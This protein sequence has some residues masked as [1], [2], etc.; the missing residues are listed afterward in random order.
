[1]N[2]RQEARECTVRPAQCQRTLPSFLNFLRIHSEPMARNKR[3]PADW[4][5]G[6]PHASREAKRYDNPIPSR[7]FLMDLLAEAGQPLPFAEI[8]E[9]IGLEDEAV[10]ALE[11]RLGAMVR[12]GQLVVT[13]RGAYGPVDKMD[14]VRGRVI[15]HPDGYG[16]LVPEA[17]GD[18]LFLS[19]RQM[20]GLLHGDK[21]LVRTVGVD[22]QGRREGTLVE[23]L[24]RNTDTL[25]GRFMEEGPLGLVVPDHKRVQHDVLVLPEN[26]GGAEPGQIVTVELTRQPDK[27]A[28]PMG[29]V[30]EVLGDHM[31]PGMEIDIAIR[32]HGIPYEWPE[33]LKDELKVF[34]R[35]VP[36]A[37]KKGRTDLRHLPLV[38]ID[39]ADAKDFDDAVYCEATPKGWRLLVAIADV[40]AYVESGVVLDQAARERTTSVYFPGRVVPMLPEVLSNGLCSLNPE[41]DRLCMVCEMQFD[42]SGAIRRSRFIEGVMR[43]HAR[44]IY[45]EVADILVARDAGLR[46][47]YQHL[48]PHLETLYD[49]YKVLRVARESRGAIDFGSSETR[50]VFGPEKKIDRILPVERNDAHKLIEECMIAA[51]VAAARFLKRHRMPALYRVHEPPGGQKLSDVREFLQGLGLSLPGGDKP[52]PIHYNQLLAAVQERPDRHLIE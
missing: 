10:V 4:R 5:S 11:R 19:P 7:E 13:R 20:R 25:V 3:K 30:V 45:D 42:A 17:G 47:Q 23:V 52:E 50:I 12:D 49:L 29:R 22:N 39:G 44:F 6:D 36:E 24:E 35:E 27:H 1:M 28:R 31:G 43:S 8:R 34:G 14:L 16:F 33:G 46:E 2:A 41:V 51:N 40:S 15:G 26:R 32:S 37:A 18:D 38:T 48:V 21:A 9:R